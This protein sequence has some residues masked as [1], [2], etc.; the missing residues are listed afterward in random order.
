[1]KQLLMIY[2]CV[3]IASTA[4]AE[5]QQSVDRFI[6]VSH[7]ITAKDSKDVETRDGLHELKISEIQFIEEEPV[8]ILGFN[9]EDYLPEDFN[10]YKI[11]FDLNSVVY[12][13]DENAL[14]L[15]FDSAYNLPEGFDAY[16]EDVSIRSINYVEDE[17][18]ELGFDTK[19][20]LP[21]NFSPHKVYFNLNTV[22]FIED[23]EDYEIELGPYNLCQTL[24]KSK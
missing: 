11:Y 8:V 19:D 14:Q 7:N 24:A 18:L 15:D 13:E 5:N 16:S 6:E 3:L 4:V 9:P 10:P 1:M 23:D 22:Q 21:E 20:Y 17:A 12:I 2:G